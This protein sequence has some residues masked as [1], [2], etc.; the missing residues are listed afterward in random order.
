MVG[1]GVPKRSFAVGRLIVI[2]LIGGSDKLHNESDVTDD[3]EG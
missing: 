1:K 2:G 3:F